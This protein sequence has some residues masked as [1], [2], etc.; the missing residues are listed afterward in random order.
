MSLFDIGVS[1]VLGWRA[2]LALALAAL[3]SVVSAGAQQEGRGRLSL[4]IE[5]QLP[6][7]RKVSAPSRIHLAD[8]RGKPVLPQGFP[9]FKDHFN[10]GGRLEIELPAGRYVWT[11][12]RGP[13]YSRA[14][15]R[16][17]VRP[18][19]TDALTA[20]LSRNFGFELAERGWYS[21]DLHIHRTPEELPLLVRSEDLHVAPILT[22]WNKESRWARRRLPEQ[23]LVEIEPTRVFHL[24]ACEDERRGGA[25]LYFNMK[26]P[27]NFSG[28]GPEFPS[29]VTHLREA[30]ERDGAWVDVEKPFWWDVPAWVATGKIRSLGIAN[31]HMCRSEMYDDE[32]W[33]RPRDRT[34]FPPPRGNGF[35][36]QDI[37]YRLLN[38]GFR[39]PPSAG[40]ASGVLPNPVGYNRVYVHSL[41]A[42]SYGAWWRGLAEGQSFVT[43]G[44]ILLVQANEAYPGHVFRRPA[45]EKLAVNLQVE[46]A[47]NDP[48]EALEVIR[49]GVIVERLNG[50]RLNRRRSSS[51]TLESNGQIRIG[52]R[53]VRPDDSAAD[54]LVFERSGWFLVRAIAAVPSTF[55]FA[56]TAPY[57][58]EIGEHRRRVHRADVAYFLRWVDERIRALK[59]DRAG[60]LRD[61]EQQSAVLEPHLNARRLFESLLVQAE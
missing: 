23:L 17:E 20:V 37:Y 54:P 4:V 3:R 45:G 56:S 6:D 55:R 16:L 48:L 15:G 43:N 12:E 50:D 33:G 59:L 41:G 27:L 44:P 24:L 31:N 1:S 9:S 40:S 39:I 26:Q 2:L 49:D 32:A 57:Y 60:H 28:D 38:C 51:L 11:V 34:A 19:A 18:D 14:S 42:F 13:E 30:I 29:P 36:S 21:G 8:D 47:G 10:S 25:Q 53:T 46:I 52:G 5:E 7:G 22:V 61:P 58:V 35:Y